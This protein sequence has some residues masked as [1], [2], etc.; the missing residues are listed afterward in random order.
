[1]GAAFAVLLSLVSFQIHAYAKPVEYTNL[2]VVVKDAET[3]QP[4]SQARLTL[5]FREPGKKFK[6][7]IAHHL[8]FSAKTNNQ[9]RYRFTQIPKGPVHLIVTADR[10]QALGKDF[11]V[12]KD[13]QVLEVELKKPQPLL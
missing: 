7:K 4:I 3:D 11:D 2:T 1:L 12:E 6:P 5:Q 8:S 10:H 13:N 9:G